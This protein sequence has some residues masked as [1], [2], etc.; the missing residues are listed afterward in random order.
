MLVRTF[1]AFFCLFLAIPIVIVVY[2]SFS[3]TSYIIFPIRGFSLKWFVRIWEYKP[4]LNSL[5]VSVQL[6][7]LSGTLACLI[8]LPAV[9]ALNKL[10]R[11]MVLA[12]ETIVLSPLAVPF[13]VFGCATLFFFSRIGLGISFLALVLAHTVV[14]IPYCFRTSVAVNRSI[15]PQMA[16]SARSLG[17]TPLQTFYRVTLPLLRPGLFAGFVFSALIS[18]DNLPVSFFFGSPSTNTLPVV[19][20]SYLEN[21]F[22]PSIAALSTVQ[23]MIAIILLFALEKAVGINKFLKPS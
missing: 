18:L 8:V 7:L 3:E 6:A 1:V 14:S 5:I 23:M 11:R 22:D 16:E 4:F 2:V 20:L 19:M 15:P 17:A 10:P 12:V 9:L 21:Q 13:I